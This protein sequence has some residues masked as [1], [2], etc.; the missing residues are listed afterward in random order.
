MFNISSFTFAPWKVVWREVA[1]ELDAAVT[2]KAAVGGVRK[3]VVP[4]HTCIL[5]GCDTSQ[6]AHFIC[7]AL[8]SSP[9]RLAIRNYIVLHPDPHVLNNINIPKFSASNRMHLRLADLSQAAH[10]AAA[11]GDSAEVA[12]VEEEIDR[13]AA[14]L[15]GLSDD[16]LAE[17]K[18][19]LEEM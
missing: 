1:N 19:S 6:E 16:E 5:V 17:I 9:A 10:R 15:W 18:R 14:R 7:A 8:N 11:K 13:T 12:R 4:D 3:P 2:G